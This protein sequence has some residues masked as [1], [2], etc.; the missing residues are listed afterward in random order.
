MA[1]KRNPDPRGKLRLHLMPPVYDQNT[2]AWQVTVHASLRAGAQSSGAKLYFRVDGVP[3]GQQNTDQNGNANMECKNLLVG[4]HEAE[5][6]S[7]T[8]ASQT[9][10]FE[11]APRLQL[12]FGEPDEAKGDGLSLSASAMVSIDGRPIEGISVQFFRDEEPYGNP[13]PTDANGRAEMAFLNLTEK[14]HMFSAQLQG[15]AIRARQS[16]AVLRKQDMRQIALVL[17]ELRAEAETKRLYATA[18]AEVS[19]GG[20]P[21]RDVPVDFYVD[22]VH[23]AQRVTGTDGRVEEHFYPHEGPRGYLVEAV[24]AGTTIRASKTLTVSGGMVRKPAA[25]NVVPVELPESQAY[26]LFIS[27]LDGDGKGVPD[28]PM[29]VVDSAA[30]TGVVGQGKTDEDGMYILLVPDVHQNCVVDVL[31]C[32]TALRCCVQLLAPRGSRRVDRS[33]TVPPML[34][35]CSV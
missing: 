7:S 5:A 30:Q 32:G 20:K 27:V 11:I 19:L 17:P 33:L 22:G 16:L 28:Q 12:E 18:V 13:Q 2:G 23:F 24:I 25:I 14:R 35:P 34:P 3:V 1:D 6:S 29:L 31:A 4:K 10:S 9:F 15:T 21:Q 26:R 8:G